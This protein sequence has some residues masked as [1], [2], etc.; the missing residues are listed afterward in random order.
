MSD[1]PE[2]PVAAVDDGVPLKPE[3]HQDQAENASSGMT[4]ILALV[5][6]NCLTKVRTP[7]ATLAE[8]VSPV[9]LMIVLWVSFNLSD[10][11]TFPSKQ[12]HALN[13]DLP[14][15]WSTGA[16][17]EEE[18]DDFDYSSRRRLVVNDGSTAENGGAVDFGLEEQDDGEDMSLGTWA[19]LLKSFGSH[20]DAGEPE[21][22]FGLVNDLLMG[23]MMRQGQTN[24]ELYEFVMEM[25]SDFDDDATLGIEGKEEDEVLDLDRP[26]AE[27]DDGEDSV[28]WYEEIMTDLRKE[29]VDKVDWDLVVDEIKDNFGDVWEQGRDYIIANTRRNM[30]R[31]L[32]EVRL[33]VRRLV[34][35]L[36]LFFVLFFTQDRICRFIGFPS[37][38]L[39]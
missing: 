24:R 22:D 35:C 7:G 3:D 8:F 4:Q 10:V 28:D 19:H 16:Y 38:T 2:K 5:H 20:G 33:R 11:L 17:A 31:T 9:L 39:S 34:F 21:E 25:D 36:V 23:H 14:M 18:L 1:R 29:T 12:Y 13:V 32:Q 6:K 26:L 27:E 37:S 15:F 30:G